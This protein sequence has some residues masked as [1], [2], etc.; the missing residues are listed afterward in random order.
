MGAFLMY[1]LMTED[2]IKRYRAEA[3]RDRQA[4]QA[5]AAMRRGKADRRS[6][7]APH[8]TTAGR[9]ADGHSAGTRRALAAAFLGVVTLG[10][11]RRRGV[12]PR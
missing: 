10:A 12:S 1:D 4:S 11:I 2:R 5:A 6:A 8:A 3:E 7:G 9:S